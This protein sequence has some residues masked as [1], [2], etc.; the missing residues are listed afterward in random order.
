MSEILKKGIVSIAIV[1]ALAS[2][3]VAQDQI[4]VG[5][6]NNGN[7]EVTTE[8]P[9]DWKDRKYRHVETRGERRQKHDENYRQEPIGTIHVGPGYNQSFAP[10][11]VSR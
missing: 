6:D 2:V 11:A 7:A 9:K 1:L 5:E 3:A 4:F 8:K 10:G